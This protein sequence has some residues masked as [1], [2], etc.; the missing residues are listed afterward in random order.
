[1]P[2]LKQRVKKQN[3]KDCGLRH[4]DHVRII[5]NPSPRGHYRSARVTIL[6]YD[7]DGVARSAVVRSVK[8][9]VSSTDRNNFTLSCSSIDRAC[10]R[11][12]ISANC[13]NLC[14]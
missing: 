3:S 6:N 8:G 1:M 9:R 10:W 2:P 12:L 11:L 4:A 7:N 5:D 14:N 13:Y